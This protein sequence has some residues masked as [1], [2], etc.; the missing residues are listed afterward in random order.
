MRSPRGEAAEELLGRTVQT[1]SRRRR[2]RAVPRGCGA[3]L[4][5][6]RARVGKTTF[7]LRARTAPAPCLRR[8]LQ[9][10]RRP[11]WPRSSPRGRRRR[12][13]RAG[14]H[15]ARGPRH[16]RGAR[17]AAPA[18]GGGRPR[19]SRA[20]PMRSAGAC[21][22]ASPTNGRRPRRPWQT[23]AT[24]APGSSW[25]PSTTRAASATSPRRPAHFVP[26]AGPA[27]AEMAL[28]RHRYDRGPAASSAPR[29]GGVASCAR[30][31]RQL[32]EYDSGPSDL[33]LRRPSRPTAAP[34]KAPQV[35]EQ[36][37]LFSYNVVVSYP[38]TH[39]VTPNCRNDVRPAVPVSGTDHTLLCTLTRA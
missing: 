19:R 2:D 4:A 29:P 31:W 7:Q 15:R 30:A 25:R 11:W 17:V 14:A 16:R 24:C 38:L 32:N 12:R 36:A 27:T 22:S 39:D 34:K 37:G 6:A 21:G 26:H 35:V 28:A 1:A 33:P 23:T 10:R 20:R 9:R 13:L 18:P 8:R 3:R 5:A